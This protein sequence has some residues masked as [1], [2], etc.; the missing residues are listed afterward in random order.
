M[1][2]Q[3][4]KSVALP[5]IAFAG[6]EKPAQIPGLALVAHLLQSAVYIF[7]RRHNGCKDNKKSPIVSVQ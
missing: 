3:S 7:S 2:T 6:L 5:V 1:S 4:Q